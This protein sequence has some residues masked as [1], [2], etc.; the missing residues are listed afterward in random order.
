MVETGR[1]THRRNILATLVL[2][3]AAGLV[4]AGAAFA[5][6]AQ[7]TLS[8]SPPQGPVGTPFTVT[9]N[10]FVAGAAVNVRWGGASGALVGQPVADETGRVAVSGTVPAEAPAGAVIINGSQ[11]TTNAQG[12]EVFFNTSVLFTVTA[13]TAQQP[14]P[15]PT[16]VTQPPA[17]PVAQAPAPAPAVQPASA[18]AVQP[19][20]SNQAAAAARTTAAAPVPAPARQPATQTSPQAAA[21]APKPDDPP[22]TPA[23]ATPDQAAAEPTP[24]ARVAEPAPAARPVPTTRTSDGGTPGWLLPAIVIGVALAVA[25]C[26]VVAGATPRRRRAR[27]GASMSGTADVSDSESGPLRSD[28]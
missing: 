7:A 11:K 9:G 17:A 4:A 18:P 3:A 13:E 16:P 19:V 28:S 2:A 12:N 6:T 22:P 14:P 10:G 24:E 8:V 23:A 1:S 5:C 27:A 15:Q 25:S 21:A 26:A 20:T